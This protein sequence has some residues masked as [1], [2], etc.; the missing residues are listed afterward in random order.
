MPTLP[1]PITEI[2]VWRLVG[3]GGDVFWIGLKKI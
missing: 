3:D 1:V 2:L